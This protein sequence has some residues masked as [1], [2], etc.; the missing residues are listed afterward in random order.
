MQLNSGIHD[1]ET[2]MIA[3]L[4]RLIGYGI[5]LLSVVYLGQRFYTNFGELISVGPTRSFYLALALVCAGYGVSLLLLVVPLAT[6]LAG[7]GVPK[8]TFRRVLDLHGHTNIAK[9]LPGNVFHWVGRQILAKKFGWSQISMGLASLVGITLITL[10][11]ILSAL[12]FATAMDVSTLPGWSTTATHGALIGMIVVIAGIWLIGA[13]A[14]NIPLLT[15]L[16]ETKAIQQFARG[17]RPLLAIGFYVTFFMIGGIFFWVLTAILIHAWQI[18]LLATLGFAYVTSWLAGYVTV[19]APAG[20]GVR[21]AALVLMLGATVG[22]A[23]A[24]TLA[25]ALRVVTTVG[26]FLLYVFAM[27]ARRQ[28]DIG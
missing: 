18:S 21:E 20:I 26:D 2:R 17:V 15:R 12:I 27:V 22:E 3:R 19:G 9:Y 16:P 23:E 4:A 11:A 5:L 25:I 8:P 13:F 7:L 28:Q 6:V 24:L 14:D 10:A 1:D